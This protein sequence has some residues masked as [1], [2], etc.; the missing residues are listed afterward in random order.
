MASP[1][2]VLA[3]SDLLHGSEPVKAYMTDFSN[4]SKRASAQDASGF[5]FRS[6]INLCLK[7]V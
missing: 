6:D 5:I 3:L 4:F 2:L 7:P 1:Q